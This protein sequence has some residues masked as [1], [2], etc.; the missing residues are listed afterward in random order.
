M[1]STTHPIVGVIATI[2]LA[3]AICHAGYWE[4]EQVDS[5][6][7]GSY[8]AVDKMS[9]GTIWLAYVNR[10]SAIRLAHKETVW[11]YED[12][13]TAMV[14]PGFPSWQSWPPFSF[15]V[16]PGDVVGVVGLGR[17]AEFSDSG[18]S[19]EQLPMPMTDMAFNY[20]SASHP[21]LTFKDSLWR[22]CLG[23]KTDSSWDT[24][25]VYIPDG[26]TMWYS[27]TRPAWR[28][29][30][31]CALI[32]ADVWSMGGLIDGY[33]VSFKRRDN[34]VWTDFGGVGGLDGGGYGFAALADSSD[35]IHT[36]WSAA[37]NYFTNKLVCD[38]VV[39]DSYTSIGAACLDDSDRVQCAW[40]IGDVLKYALANEPTI[41]VGSGSIEWCDITTDALSQPVIAYCTSDGSIYVTHGF[42]VA[43]LSSKPKGTAI[44]LQR[45]GP[46]IVRGAL[47]LPDSP[48]TTSSSLISIDG[49]KVTDLRP[50]TND[51]SGIAPGVYFVREA[52]TQA[53]SSKPQAVRKIV[54]SR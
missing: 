18:W 5:G 29:S 49:R 40:V 6:S 37:D 46:S 34:G 44:H 32:E 33:G 45:S 35:S 52:Q 51:I 20:D 26:N 12:L 21:S 9:D 10:D 43:G 17:L 25:V 11:E 41:E 36:F 38:D 27:L 47:F 7:L 39:L 28:R 30:G 2:A 4:F 22:G 23:L 3:V 31:N 1:R 42:D 16:G 19:S 53:A 54:I 48:L 24:D 14:S 13:D 8:V 50:G 15:D